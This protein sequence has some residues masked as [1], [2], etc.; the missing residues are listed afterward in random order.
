MREYRYVNL[1]ERSRRSWFIPPGYVANGGAASVMMRLTLSCRPQF[2]AIWN[3]YAFEIAFRER[4]PAD[5]ITPF[6]FM[7]M[8][9]EAGISLDG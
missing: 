8:W 2:V 3:L 5:L 6:A 1:E 9:R 4:F 7:T